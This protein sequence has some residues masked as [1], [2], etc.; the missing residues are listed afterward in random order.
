MLPLKQR[1]HAAP[2]VLVIPPG[3]EKKFLSHL[4]VERL[5]V[6]SGMKERL[7]LLGL[8]TLGHI[9][10]FSLPALLS[11]FGAEGKV[12][13]EL[14]R[15]IE[16]R[17]RIPGSLTISEIEEDMILDSPRI[18]GIR[19]GRH[20]RTFL[21]SFAEELEDAGM[22]CRMVELTLYLRNKNAVRNILYSTRPRRVK[23][24]C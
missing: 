17:G 11:Q 7:T 14:A 2:H 3:G 6:S 15:G 4:S 9:H 22:A 18:R 8:N 19:S 24:T 20:S 12:L 13:W 16:N 10:P 1:V 5:P 23:M 21:I